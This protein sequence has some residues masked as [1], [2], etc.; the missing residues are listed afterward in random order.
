MRHDGATGEVTAGQP[1]RIL[2]VLD[3]SAGQS[4]SKGVGEGRRKACG[5]PWHTS[6]EARACMHE[7]HGLEKRYL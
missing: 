7:P 2:T 4:Q 3:A 5:G 1:M 6:P